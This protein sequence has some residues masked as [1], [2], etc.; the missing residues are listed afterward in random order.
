VLPTVELDDQLG[1]DTGEVGEVA[2]DRMLAAEL[3]AGKL[4]VAEGLPE[5]TLGVG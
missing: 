5:G 2:A 4:A 3:V 1:F